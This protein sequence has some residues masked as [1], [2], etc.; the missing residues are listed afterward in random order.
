MIS[1]LTTVNK[2]GAIAKKYENLM[3]KE[4][5]YELLWMA[6]E[7]QKGLVMHIIYWEQKMYIASHLN[8]A[9]SIIEKLVDCL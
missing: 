8:V 6:S 1:D 3:H 5:F 9:Y 7:K 4:K 2:F